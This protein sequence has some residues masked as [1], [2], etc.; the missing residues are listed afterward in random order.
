[1]TWL[2]RQMKENKRSLKSSLTI[3]LASVI[4][5]SAIMALCFAI[6]G[7]Y[8]FGQLTVMTG[9]TTYQFVDYLAYLRTVF[10][11][12]N[13]FSYSLS[14][15][16]GGEMAGFAAYYFY[17]PFNLITLL[18]PAEFL[19]A[20]IFAIL[21]SA[22][23]LCSLCM[24]IAL[25][26]MYGLKWSTLLFSYAYGLMA[27]VVVY[28]ELFEYYTNFCLLPFIF[29]GL[30]RLIDRK[31]TD[32]LY[33]FTLA[34]AIINHYYT[35]YMICIFCACYFVYRVILEKDGYKSTGAFAVSSL[36]AGGLSS[37]VLLPA[38]MSLSDEKNALSIGFVRLFNP[39]DLFSKLYTGSFKGDFGAGLPNIYCGLTT[40]LLFVTLFFNK[41]ISVK[42]KILTALAAAFFMVNFCI[43][44]FNV[45]WHGFNRPIG[46]PHRF[47][48][49]FVFF[50]IIKAGEAFE[51][52]GDSDIK[53][54]GVLTFG[55][56]ALYSVYL[57][58]SQNSNTSLP[59]IVI[60]LAVLV[61]SACLL[62]FFSGGKR[63]F[64]FLLIGLQAADLGI[65]ALLTL[66]S[67]SLT[68]MEEY[69]QAY[70][71]SDELVGKVK[72]G[73]NGL[74]RLEK[75]F[76]RT[77]NDAFMH[78]YAGLSHF[79]SSEKMSTIRYMGKLGFR[80]NGNW[81]FYGDGNGVLADSLL[82]VK[83]LL[84]QYGSAGKPYEEIYENGQGYSVF[85]NPYALPL[86]FAS[87]NGVYDMDHMSY[88]DPLK[89]Q[90]EIA[91]R[92]NGKENHILEKLEVKRPTGNRFSFTTEKYGLVDVY[93]TAPEEQDVRIFINGSDYGPYFNTYRWNVL[94]L[95]VY[96]KGTEMEISF[97]SS[98]GDPVRVDD[99]FVY[100]EDF[101]ALER[102]YEDVTRD[103][104]EL[105]KITSS[106]YEGRADLSKDKSELVFSV[107][108]DNGWRAYVDDKRTEVRKACGDLIGI[109]AGEGEHRVRFEYI[110]PGRTLGYVLSLASLLALATLFLRGILKK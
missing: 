10:F 30:T 54:A 20:G 63:A 97:E 105:K 102:F 27:F 48:Y 101:D 15:N 25:G 23:G 81:A 57:I 93:F 69:R 4:L 107:P 88:E 98:D 40:I 49:L 74:Y 108:Y 64:I 55:F 41:K 46:F 60:T 92:I 2:I 39:L 51:G 65:N 110:P 45:V 5:P 91:D 37:F 43:N 87:K 47:A 100:N 42:E 33:I 44:T 67:F 22:P 19:P 66:N 76:R 17:S 84:S 59:D 6:R 61:L 103:E 21:V 80:D 50:L 58:I 70:R 38:L 36:L 75:Y 12:N 7:A 89:L 52:L 28:N 99:A 95:G 85:R 13:D 78:D 9:D 31:R 73:D 77:H 26:K 96:E 68:P 72:E 106:H 14:K 79:S 104:T 62:I 94:N 29:Y 18:F 24:C 90:E 1:M 16:L 83:Y 8:P 86:M 71:I 35:G 11:G 3:Y 109:T 34:F 82:G 53:K 56:F 32:A